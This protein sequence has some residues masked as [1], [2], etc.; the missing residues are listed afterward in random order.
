MTTPVGTHHRAAELPERPRLIKGIGAFQRTQDELQVGLDPRHAIVSSDLPRAVIRLLSTL[1]GRTPLSVL[2]D[3][4]GAAHGRLL[5]ELLIGLHERGLL[6]GA[7]PAANDR[8]AR[9]EQDF[10][11]WTLR[12]GEPRGA[13][14]ARRR[15]V[16]VVVRGDGRLAVAISTLLAASGIGHVVPD[17][18]GVVVEAEV[19]HDYEQSD[20]G[21]RR[22]NAIASMVRRVNPSALTSSLPSDRSPELVVLTDAVVPTPE[23]VE[24]LMCERQP[25]LP[26]RFRDGTGVVGPLVLPGRTACLR[27]ADL[28]RTDL[29]PHWP[30]VSNQLAGKV[31]GADPASTHATAALAT[32]QVLRAVQYGGKRPP[33]WNATVELDLCEGATRRRHWHPHPRC[34]CCSDA[35]W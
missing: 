34:G 9:L 19:G 11:L 22:R 15:M 14:L 6:I 30:R 23:V 31:G 29:D 2:L 25:H 27:C 17:A 1:D 18:A 13:A 21:L 24:Q 3:R 32:A 16:A 7:A 8:A 26:V 35:N 4:A 5:H 10:E 33:L 12:S 20:V 28:H